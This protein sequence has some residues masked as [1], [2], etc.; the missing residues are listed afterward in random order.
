MI[1]ANKLKGLPLNVSVIRL[2]GFGQLRE[3][4]IED[5][6]IATNSTLISRDKGT[7]LKDFNPNFLGEVEQIVITM[8]DSI[9]K[10]KDISST[11]IDLKQTDKI[12]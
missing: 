2:P 5:L 9:I 1:I 4:L 11:G 3:D 7:T 12:E 8:T 10:F 6:C